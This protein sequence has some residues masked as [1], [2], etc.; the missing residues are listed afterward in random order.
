[1]GGSSDYVY[2]QASTP[3]PTPTNTPTPTPT[4]TATPRP[5]NT[6][7]PT[8]TPRPTNTPVPTPT[9]TPI[10]PPTKPSGLKASLASPTSVRLEW[11]DSAG[12]TFYELERRAV[13]G[14]GQ[15]LKVLGPNTTTFTD[16]GLVAGKTYEYRLR[17]SNPGGSSDYA[18][19]RI[20]APEPT[21]KP[22]PTPTDTN[23][24]RTT[25]T[26]ELT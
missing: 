14:T 12:E 9:P 1:M 2:A 6:P 23:T 8:P 5:T 4:A 17:A 13:D 7:T 26:T 24:Q 3:A 11:K 15:M 25:A 20:S 22:T 16:R 19:V 10:P 18:Y 21:N